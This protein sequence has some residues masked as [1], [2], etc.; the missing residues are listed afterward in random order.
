[1]TGCVLTAVLG[2]ATVWWYTMGGAISEA[3]MEHEERMKLEA[4][5]KRG[6]FFGLLKKK[7]D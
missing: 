2:M 1:M 6:K 3:E 5:E 4:K 7:N